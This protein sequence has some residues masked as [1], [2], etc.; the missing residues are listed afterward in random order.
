[1]LGRWLNCFG[2][3]LTSVLSKIDALAGRIAAASFDYC[4]LAS[5]EFVKR[6]RPTSG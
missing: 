2:L 6:Y 5:S 4:H 1:M 3:L